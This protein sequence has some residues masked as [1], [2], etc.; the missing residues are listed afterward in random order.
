M[1]TTR[2][3]FALCIQGAF[4]LAVAAYW[5]RQRIMKEEVMEIALVKVTR[6]V[7]F[8]HPGQL[9]EG[10]IYLVTLCDAKEGFE[11]YLKR[12]TDDADAICLYD[13]PPNVP[14]GKWQPPKGG[15]GC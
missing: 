5:W 4:C 14:G 10:C 15:D 7:V 12:W 11:E 2:E 13:G 9:R 6:I 3:W 1:E 8:V